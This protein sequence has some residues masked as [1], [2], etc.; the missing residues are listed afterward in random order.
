[1]RSTLTTVRNLSFILLV[2][3]ALPRGGVAA[4]PGEGGG[5]ACGFD[6]D[7]SNCP[8][9]CAGIT[10]YCGDEI[11]DACEMPDGQY[12][13]TCPEDCGECR[14][15]SDCLGH[16]C[17]GEFGYPQTNV[18]CGAFEYCDLELARCVEIPGPH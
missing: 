13:Q 3:L 10:C 5:D 18:C 2:L 8:Q 11:C 4:A 7:C 6:E 9:D 14:D 15:N 12:C 1:M 17:C 16:D